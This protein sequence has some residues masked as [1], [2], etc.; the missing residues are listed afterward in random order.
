M[1]DDRLDLD[2]S[3]GGGQLLRT[4]LALSTVADR[5]FRMESI[6]GDRPTPGLKPQHL[7]AVRAA[8]E[9][10][11]ATVSGA[12]PGSEELEFR[13]GPLDGVGRVDSRRDRGALGTLAP[14]GRQ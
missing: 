2:G 1:A 7:A 5:P 6:R 11:D 9:V 3:A 12:E 10:C 8:A 14:V 13:P 4:A